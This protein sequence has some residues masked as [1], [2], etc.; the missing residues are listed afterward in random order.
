MIDW[1][2][3][4]IA[5]KGGLFGISKKVAFYG[6]FLLIVSNIISYYK[7]PNIDFV[8][9]PEIEATLLSGK[10]ISLYQYRDKPLMIHF[11]ATWCPTCKLEAPTIDKLS[12][13]YQ[14]LTIAV[15]SGTDEEIDAFMRENGY[16]FPVIHDKHSEIAKAYKI[17]AFPTTYILDENGNVDFID[18]GFTSDVGLRLRMWRAEKD[19]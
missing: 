1:L 15:N 11:W 4:Y 5:K 2:K 6:L 8:T 10:N 9:A 17:S 16:S 12:H 19:K 14:V 13:E 3:G 7:R 18:V